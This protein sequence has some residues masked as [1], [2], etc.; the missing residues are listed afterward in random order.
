MSHISD[1]D[2]GGSESEDEDFNPAPPIDSDDEPTNDSATDR[3]KQS[4]A[5]ESEV[6]AQKMQDDNADSPA[7]GDSDLEPRSKSVN[8]AVSGSKSAAEHKDTRKGGS[9]TEKGEDEEVNN[10]DEEGD[11]EDV[12]EDEV[13]EDEDDEDDEEEV[14]V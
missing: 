11:D 7:E 6:Y 13:E 5:S 12:A 14:T 8:G 1:H 2:I 4:K 3:R 9:E 10:H